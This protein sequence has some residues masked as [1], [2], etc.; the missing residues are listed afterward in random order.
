MMELLEQLPPQDMV[1]EQSVLGSMI[2]ERVAIRRALDLGLVEQDF[3]REPHGLLFRVLVAMHEGGMPVDMTTLQTRLSAEGVLEEIGGL[4]YLATLLDAVP[5]AANVEAYVATVRE[6]AMRRRL[7]ETGLRI[8]SLAHQCADGG[9]TLE[10][11]SRMMAE[12]GERYATNGKADFTRL[13]EAITAKI[14]ELERRAQQDEHVTGLRTGIEALDWCTTGLHPGNYALIAA[15]TSRGKSAL[16]I[17]FAAHMAFAGHAVAFFS[18]EMSTPEL[19]DRIIANRA[20]VDGQNLRTGQLGDHGWQQVMEIGVRADKTPLLIFDRSLDLGQL[21]R[22]ARRAVLDE[23]ARVIVVDYVQLVNVRGRDERRIQV[24]TVSR[25]LKE[26]ARD[27]GVAVI[28]LSQ[29]RRRPASERENFR[30]SLADLKETGDLEN[31]ADLILFLFD[32]DFRPEADAHTPRQVE[33]L[34]AKQRN[35]PLARIA[36]WWEP[37][38]QRFAEVE[39]RRE[40]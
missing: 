1:A 8:G 30:P 4:P 22:M 37:W 24:G 34:V 6:M 21:Q 26:I 40:A 10:E 32:P 28:G 5:T 25:G 36:L 12:I 31:D 38:R 17:Q 39:N 29:L 15:Q 9:A 7:I 2:L 19:M 18:L 20:G 3:Y 13:P 23:G 35:G 33:L 14:A 11:C 27:L 16:A